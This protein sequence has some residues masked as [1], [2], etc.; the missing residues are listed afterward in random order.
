MDVF[1]TFRS[2]GDYLYV[3]VNSFMLPRLSL[4]RMAWTYLVALGMTW[5]AWLPRGQSAGCS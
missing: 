5:W 2:Y 3:G 1:A 4:M